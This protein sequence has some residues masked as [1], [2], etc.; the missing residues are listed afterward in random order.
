LAEKS[1]APRFLSSLMQRAS[2]R[3]CTA[4]RSCTVSP[5]WEKVV[6]TLGVKVGF[7]T[8]FKIVSMKTHII[9]SCL[10]G[11]SP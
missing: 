4:A 2:K 10:F 9:N 3:V 11:S 6:Y 5:I 8:F 7:A 1:S